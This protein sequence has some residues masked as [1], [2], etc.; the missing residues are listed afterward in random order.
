MM[1]HPQPPNQ[2]QPSKK[3][4]SP[5]PISNNTRSNLVTKPNN[6]PNANIN[7][8]LTQH[9]N[10]SNNNNIPQQHQYTF[11]TVINNGSGNSINTGNQVCR[12]IIQNYYKLS[13]N[14]K[15]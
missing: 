13:A 8:N 11:G 14:I 2:C 5:N 3:P 9:N 6:R 4:H 12:E 10:T 1:Y 7:T 15:K